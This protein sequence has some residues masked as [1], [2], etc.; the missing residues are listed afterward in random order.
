MLPLLHHRLE[1]Q[2]ELQT[3]T[4]AIHGLVVSRLAENC[5]NIGLELGVEQE[6]GGAW[7]KDGGGHYGM[8][9]AASTNDRRGF[10]R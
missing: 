8:V 4:E 9:A 1:E 5:M 7:H 2:N 6:R 10:G 3:G